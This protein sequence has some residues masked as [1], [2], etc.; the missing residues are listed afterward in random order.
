[1][2]NFQNSI[3][4]NYLPVVQLDRTSV[5]GTEGRWFESS[6]AG[7]KY[8]KRKGMIK[9]QMRKAVYIITILVIGVLVGIVFNNNAAANETNTVLPEKKPVSIQ[10]QTKLNSFGSWLND[11]P[12]AIGNWATN[13]WEE[14]K[15]FQKTNWQSGK[16]QTAKNFEKI[17]SFLVDK[18]SK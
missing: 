7:Q 1:M 2:T 12:E 5:C 16:E 6:Q 13:E 15:Q 4:Y 10:L 17:K 14:I 9:K 8:N 11:R 18:T 3:Y